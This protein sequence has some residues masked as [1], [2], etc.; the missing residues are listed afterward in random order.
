[1]STGVLFNATILFGDLKETFEVKVSNSSRE[2]LENSCLSVPS[3][4]SSFED[5]PF[6][7]INSKF[8]SDISFVFEIQ[9][10]L[11]EKKTRCLL[12][13]QEI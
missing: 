2:I 11:G 9:A 13:L 7:A 6:V 5:A 3:A 8:S 4:E 10:T 12:S 1:M